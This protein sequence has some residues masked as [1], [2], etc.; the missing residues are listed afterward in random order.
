MKKF[1]VLCI[2]ALISFSCCNND[3]KERYYGT[4]IAVDYPQDKP[5]FVKISAD[6]IA[7]GENEMIWNTY[8][9]AICN[10]RLSFNG[11]TFISSIS[12]SLLTIEDQQ[13]TKFKIEI[14]CHNS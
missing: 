11:Q 8:P 5:V 14:N 4:W 9:V 1:I 7:Y 3:Q 13:Y 10:Q 6:S 12:D 2:A